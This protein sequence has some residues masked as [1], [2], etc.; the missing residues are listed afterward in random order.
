MCAYVFISYKCYN[1]YIGSTVPHTVLVQIEA[2]LKYR[3]GLK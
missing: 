1:R 3:L 2:V